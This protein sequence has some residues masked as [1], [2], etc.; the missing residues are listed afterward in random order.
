MKDEAFAQ[1]MRDLASAEVRAA[2]RRAVDVKA[3]FDRRGFRADL[4]LVAWRTA[5]RLAE[6]LRHPRY[7][8]TR[9]PLKLP[10]IADGMFR[11]DAAEE[12]RTSDTLHAARQRAPMSPPPH[13]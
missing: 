9:D 7:S 5:N 4:A 2:R 13:E 10:A 1:F 6:T 12:L 3:E 11:A 8:E